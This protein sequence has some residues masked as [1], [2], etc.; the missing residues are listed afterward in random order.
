[1]IFEM[2]ICNTTGDT[3]GGG[4]AYPSRA[5]DFNSG[6]SG[7]RIAQSFVFCVVLCR[8]LF[9]ILSFFPLTILLSVFPQLTAYNIDVF[10]FFLTNTKY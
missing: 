9:G 5:P 10:I 6:F 2:G 1:M 3:S 4:T 7:V 8:F